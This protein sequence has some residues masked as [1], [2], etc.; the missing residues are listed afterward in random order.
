M[1][2]PPIYWPGFPNLPGGQP[3]GIWGGGNVPMPNPPIY[4]PGFP[5]LPG[6]QPP[7]IWGGPGSLPPFPMPPIFY[8]PHIWGPPDMPPGFWGG[9][10]G[11]G[12]RPQPRPEH[13]IVLPP[14]YV[15]PTGPGVKPPVTPIPPGEVPPHPSTGVTSLYIWVPYVGVVGPIYVP[16]GV[17]APPAKA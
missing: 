1:P 8:P 11:P 2:S 7:Q 12:V 5:N 17:D 15:P 16:P 3:P 10:M 4:W 9:G 14:D 6:G 13:P